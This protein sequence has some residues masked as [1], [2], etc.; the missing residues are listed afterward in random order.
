MNLYVRLKANRVMAE[1]AVIANAPAGQAAMP[2]VV[3]TQE[4]VTPQLIVLGGVTHEPSPNKLVEK[5][6]CS[7][8]SEVSKGWSKTMIISP[9]MRMTGERRMSPGCI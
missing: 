7:Q 5:I 6:S 2:N 9:G 8:S 3:F 4:V 1:E